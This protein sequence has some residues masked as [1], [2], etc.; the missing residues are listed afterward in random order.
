[1][2]F[3]TRMI[4]YVTLGSSHPIRRLSA[5]YL[6]LIV[7]GLLVFRFVPVLDALLLRDCPDNES[8]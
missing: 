3:F 7:A 4:S 8:G 5:Y 1:M 2:G 6:L